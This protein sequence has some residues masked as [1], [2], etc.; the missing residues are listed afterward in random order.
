MAEVENERLEEPQA[1]E[2]WSE[3][4]SSGLGRITTLMSSEQIRLPA[5]DMH[6]ISKFNTLAERAKKFVSLCS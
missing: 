1:K 3:S 4:P 2:Y 6:S 5:E